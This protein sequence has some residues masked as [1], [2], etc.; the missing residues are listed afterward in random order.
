MSTPLPYIAPKRKPAFD[1]QMSEPPPESLVEKNA[2]LVQ[3]LAGA[4]DKITGL[5]RQLSEKNERI[6]ELEGFAG[7]LINRLARRTGENLRL[8]RQLREAGLTMEELT[9]YS[10]E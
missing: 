10:A 1:L 4:N 3:Q 7:A 6:S 9:P 2:S 5:S 8:L